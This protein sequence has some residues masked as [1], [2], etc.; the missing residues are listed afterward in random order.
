MDSRAAAFVHY[1]ARE[2]YI[3]HV[4]SVCNE[5]INHGSSPVLQF[6][7]A[8]GLL[9]AGATTEV[10]SRQ[11]LMRA[12][13]RWDWSCCRV[14]KPGKHSLFTLMQ[15]IRELYAVQQHPDVGLAAT[16]A[17][18]TAHQAAKVVDNAAVMQLSAYLEVRG[19][20]GIAYI[21]QHTA[22]VPGAPP[23]A[24]TQRHTPAQALDSLSATQVEEGSASGAAALHLAAYL[25]YSHSF[26]RARSLL[27]RQT[28]PHAAA[29]PAEA[30]RAQ[31]LLGFVL[32]EQQAQEEAELQDSSELHQALQLFDAVLQQ[33]PQDLE[34]TSTA[35]ARTWQHTP[36]PG[37][38]CLS[39]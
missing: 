8:Y 31:A 1:Y 7:R 35:A 25:F 26:E 3:Q 6:W 18:L 2:G 16:A 27:E 32:L 29:D 23:H 20:H 9:A 37:C 28:G 14:M 12:V 4:Q 39:V 33:D 13:D 17:L 34:V 11:Q 30:L 24:D 5:L 38:L 36:A 15:A 22:S 19:A 10:G 21:Q